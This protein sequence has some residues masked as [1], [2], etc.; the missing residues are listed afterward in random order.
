MIRRRFFA[1]IVLLHASTRSG[2]PPE[3]NAWL[4]VQTVVARQSLALCLLKTD[5]YIA[6]NVLKSVASHRVASAEVFAVIQCDG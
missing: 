6:P 3:K 4:F 5:Q 1:T 2:K